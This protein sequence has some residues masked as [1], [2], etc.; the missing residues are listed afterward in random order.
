[1]P[2]LICIYIYIYIYLRI[3]IYSQDRLHYKDIY[4]YIYSSTVRIDVPRARATVGHLGP[5]LVMPNRQ[6]LPPCRG[7]NSYGAGCV[8]QLRYTLET[9][10]S[11]QL[12]AENV[13]ATSSP[14]AVPLF[15]ARLLR[16]SGTQ[17]WN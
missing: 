6:R 8:Q 3:Y 11:S 7:R 17:R 4:I 2:Q 14:K 12:I 16:A 15:V 9:G 1:M 13:G 5:D 10:P